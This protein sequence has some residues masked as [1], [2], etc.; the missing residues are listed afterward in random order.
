MT[1][2]LSIR[3]VRHRISVVFPLLCGLILAT[4]LVLILLDIPSTHPTVNDGIYAQ[5][6]EQQGG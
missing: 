2:S 6:E 4:A 3:M 1:L 5:F